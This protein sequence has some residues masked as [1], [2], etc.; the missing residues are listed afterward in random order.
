MMLPFTSTATT[1]ID[2]ASTALAVSIIIQ[3]TKFL[4]SYIIKPTEPNQNAVVRLFVFI[5]SLAV[6]LVDRGASGQLTSG[7]AIVAT[8]GDAFAV[9]TLSI[10]TYHIIGGLDPLSR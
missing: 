2:I 5:V 10:A 8:F 6:V 3:L 9:M 4:L 7:P 1:P